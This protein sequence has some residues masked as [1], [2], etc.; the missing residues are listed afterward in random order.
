MKNTKYE[1]SWNSIRRSIVN[2]YIECAINII[3]GAINNFQEEIMGKIQ[4]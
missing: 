4:Q 1:K 3:K 2:E